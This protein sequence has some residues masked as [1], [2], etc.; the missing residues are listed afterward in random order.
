MSCTSL[1]E[2]SEG[3]NK[4]MDVKSLWRNVSSTMYTNVNSY[5]YWITRIW[6]NCIIQR[7]CRYAGN[8]LVWKELGQEASYISNQNPQWVFAIITSK[9]TIH[10]HPFHHHG[11]HDKMEHVLLTEVGSLW[12][13][14]LKDRESTSLHKAHWSNPSGFPHRSSLSPLPWPLCLSALPMSLMFPCPSALTRNVSH[15]Q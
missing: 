12:R 9:C 11:P 13:W 2:L 14:I 10:S 5:F 8:S 1:T 7:G 6:L 15:E 3:L 4:R